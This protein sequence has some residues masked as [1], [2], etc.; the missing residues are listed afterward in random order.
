MFRALLTATLTL[1]LAAQAAA[2]ETAP[3]STAQPSPAPGW[4]DRGELTGDWNGVR[5]TLQSKAGTTFE[6]SLTQFFDWAP[7]G[8]DDRGFDY[9]G[10]IDVKSRTSLSKWLWDNSL[11]TA[12]VEMRYGDTPLAAGGTLIPT[13]AA[14]LFPE[15]E[16]THARLSSLYFT[17]VFKGKYVLQAG[18]FNTLDLYGA[19]P[20]TGGEGIDR[21]MNLSLVAPPVSARTVPP[22]TEGVLFSVL[23]GRSPALTVG[24]IESTED[25]F[26]D[27]GVTFMWS[28]SP[29]WRLSTLPGG[30]SFGGE[31]SS[32][33][34]TS[35]DQSPWALLPDSPV[36]LRREQGTWTL[37]LTVDQFLRMHPSDPTKGWGVFGMFGISDGNLSIL[38]VQAFA[39][40]G[41]AAPFRGRSRDSWG[42]GYFLNGV[43]GDLRETLDPLLRTR[44]EHG[45]EIYYSWAPVGWSRVTADLQIIDPFLVR[46]ETRL[47]FALRWKVMF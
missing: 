6:A 30:M 1:Q 39:G 41:G 28:V 22:V 16:G 31:L 44:D 43:S 3:I 45:A 20:F 33:E 4:R 21:F 7:E 46:S 17:Q 19:H 2:Q 5:A 25:G 18:R 27:N 38:E 23:R 12:H 40:L 37:N 35:L 9:G 29:P 14:L 13:S 32:F 42:V 34:G 47:F 11:L 26:F 10:K 36:P 8:D 15:S 24:V